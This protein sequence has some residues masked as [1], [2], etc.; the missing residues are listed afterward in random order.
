MDED[1]SK[2]LREQHATILEK[3]GTVET[4]IATAKGAFSTA[5]GVFIATGALGSFL[6]VILSGIAVYAFNKIESNSEKIS[7][8][9]TRM[10]VIEVKYETE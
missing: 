6:V 5:K 10:S 9:D 7:N 4:E 3:L 2:A 1:E 8:L